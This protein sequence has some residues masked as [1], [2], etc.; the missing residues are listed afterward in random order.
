MCFIVCFLNMGGETIE[1]EDEEKGIREEEKGSR[2]R[3]KGSRY[4]KRKGVERKEGEK[5]K[6]KKG[7]RE[8]GK[9]EK[10][11]RKREIYSTSLGPG[12]LTRY[13]EGA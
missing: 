8:K 11:K 3:K 7:K 1:D 13:S 2:K 5:G 6:K 10:G 4:D 9:R 12:S